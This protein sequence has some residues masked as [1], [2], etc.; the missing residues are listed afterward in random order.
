MNLTDDE[1]IMEVLDRAM[2]SDL[3]RVRMVSACKDFIRNL[4]EE[5][6]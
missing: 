6:N 1:L 2:K 5:N 4:E 3:F